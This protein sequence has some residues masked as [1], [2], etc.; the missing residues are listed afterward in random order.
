[1]ALTD[2]AIKNAKP[3]EKPYKLAD[4]GGLSLYV[5]T[6]G[7]RLW[8]YKYR[9]AGKEGIFSIGAYP[10]VSLSK[11]REEHQKARELVKLSTHPT[12][13]RQ[14]KKLVEQHESGNTFKAIANE[15]VNKNKGRW[16]PYYLKQVEKLMGSDVFPKIGALPI[17][18]VTAAHI[19]DV[20]Q[21]AENR[22][23]ETIAILIRQ[24]CSAIFRYAAAS[25][26]A[27]ADPAAALKGVVVRPKVKHNRPLSSKEIPQVVS[28]LQKFGG[29][30]STKIA[31]ELLL[32]TFVRTIEL[33]K[34]TW[35]EFDLE[36]SIWRIPA[37]RMKMKSEHIVP[38]SFQATALIKEL[39][40]I[41]G[42]S[43]WLFPNYRRPD[44]CMTST[45]INR[46]LE[47]MGYNGK[48]TIGFSAHGFRGTAS[49][50]LYEQGFRTEVIEKQLAHA[51]GNKV[52]AS[53][54]QAQYLEERAKMMQQ[55][56]NYLDSLKT[57]GKVIPLKSAN[58]K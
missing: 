17:K 20:M 53:Y 7:A 57:E 18:Q 4:G 52:K 56:A 34:A 24:W 38:L 19:L 16:S 43:N 8:R 32:L 46:A 21:R 28:A 45:T 26:R 6:T 23:A 1:M 25:L 14:L 51:E 50:L 5:S 44:D 2:I 48:D 33:R 35:E 9:I 12:H 11:A 27:D 49:T 10:E 40:S 22:G 13:D 29:F 55:W 36:N 39:Q 31:I 3:K 47:R 54:N 41:T 58:Q 15:W 30:R 37:A 42:A